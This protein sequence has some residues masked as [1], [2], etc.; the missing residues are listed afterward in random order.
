MALYRGG[1]RDEARQSFR[2]AQIVRP[3]DPVAYLNTALIE[4]TDRNG[5]AA[6]RLLEGALARNADSTVVIPYLATAWVLERNES[7]ARALL[8]RL[9]GRTPGGPTADS[10][11]ADIHLRLRDTIAA[12]R[13]LNDAAARGDTTASTILRQLQPA[14]SSSER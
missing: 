8:Q 5:A 12:L 7:G 10:R 13:V 14:T 9:S 1:R 6:T 2:A 4:L 3:E 11:L